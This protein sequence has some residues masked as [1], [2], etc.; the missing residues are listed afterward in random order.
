MSDL[1]SQPGT[2]EGMNIAF[3]ATRRASVNRLSVAIEVVNQRRPLCTVS[4]EGTSEHV[5][6]VFSR[7]PFHL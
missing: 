5:G 7:T 6:F 4:P 3:L 2:G 1:S